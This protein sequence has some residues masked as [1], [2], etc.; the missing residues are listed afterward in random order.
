MKREIHALCSGKGCGRST[1]IYIIRN[2]KELGWDVPPEDKN[3][4][5]PICKKNK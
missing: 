4:L 3:Q 2:L 5:C 1:I